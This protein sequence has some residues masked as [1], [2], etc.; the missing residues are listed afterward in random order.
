MPRRSRT[1]GLKFWTIM[2]AFLRQVC[3]HL[4]PRFVL[5]VE[6]HT[7]LVS[8][9]VYGGK[10]NIV[11]VFSGERNAVGA[12]VGRVAAAGVAVQGVLDFDDARAEPAEQQRGDRAGERYRQ[13]QNGDVF[14]RGRKARF[15]RF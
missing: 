8:Q 11:G 12:N 5:Q 6:G 7:Q 3:E 14:Q 1:P 4:P 13:I 10:R 2:S 9:P 15:I